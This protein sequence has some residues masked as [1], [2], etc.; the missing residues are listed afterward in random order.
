MKI[1]RNGRKGWEQKIT[2]FNKQNKKK[3]LIKRE[4]YT[5]EYVWETRRG[6]S[7]INKEEERKA[8]RNREN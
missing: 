2:K 8:R 7:T 3:R 6:R 4:S 5:K 1:K